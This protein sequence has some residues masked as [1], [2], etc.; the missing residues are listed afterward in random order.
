MH[1][2]VKYLFQP[3]TCAGTNFVRKDKVGGDGAAANNWW[4]VN[5]GTKDLT[6]NAFRDDV[7]ITWAREQLE[8][9][10]VSPDSSSLLSGGLILGWALVQSILVADELPGGLTRTNFVVAQRALDMTHPMFIEGIRFHMDGNR[11][12]YFIEGGQYQQW[13]SAQQTW[14]PRSQVID[15]DG[16]STNCSWNA[17]AAICE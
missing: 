1:E 10:G 9:A 12:S 2:S 8:A 16:Q 3:I 11:D 5:S 17:T 13:D 7:Y 6:D 4:I 15:L 14:I